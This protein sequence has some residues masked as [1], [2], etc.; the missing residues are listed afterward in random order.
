MG[1]LIDPPELYRQDPPPFGSSVRKYF[2]FEYTNLNSG[3][4]GAMPKPVQSSVNKFLGKIE[5]NPDHFHMIGYQPFLLEARRKMSQHVGADSDELVLIPNTSTGIAV[6]LKNFDWNEKDVIV[7]FSTT[8]RTISKALQ[9]TADMVPQPSLSQITLQF[10]TTHAEIVATFKNHIDKIPR[11]E[12]TRVVAIIDS[13]HSTPGVLTPWKELVKVC[14]EKDVWSIVDAAHSVGQELDINLGQVQPD[15]W[16]ANCYKWFF[17]KRPSGLLYVP[18]RNQMLI[19]SS[20]PTS[21]FYTPSN[22]RT[23]TDFLAQFE[24]NGGIDLSSLFSVVH[25]LEFRNWLGGEEKIIKYCHKL[26]LEGGTRL[27]KVLKTKVMDNTEE[28]T[29]NMVNVQLP[30]PS[31]LAPS[32]DLTVAFLKKLLEEHYVSCSP[33]YHNGAWWVRCCAQIW[34]ELDD[35]DVL[36]KALLIVCPEIV[37]EYGPHVSSHSSKL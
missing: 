1:D 18:R 2:P 34:N 14:K 13:L 11:S 16:T 37:Q 15:F 23:T 10:P 4:F 30:L 6:I 17:A 26:A 5:S 22:D 33:F 36:G 9:M 12:N 32:L 31:D 35:F 20:I 21:G 19:K 25:A 29:C 28:L 24:W 3:A 27:A 8:Y 7:S